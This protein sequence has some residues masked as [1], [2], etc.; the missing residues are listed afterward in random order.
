[1]F[2]VFATEYSSKRRKR[3]W[4]YSQYV[5]YYFTRSRNKFNI[6]NVKN[7]TSCPLRINQSL[8]IALQFVKRTIQFSERTNYVVLFTRIDNYNLNFVD[9]ILRHELI[10]S[11][12]LH[13]IKWYDLHFRNSSV[14]SIIRL[15]TYFHL[16]FFFI[17]KQ[18]M[19]IFKKSLRWS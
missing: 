2:S 18:T 14:V 6:K 19:I 11:S 12:D 10:L 3:S 5:I 4:T 15:S 8:R 1:M 7:W 13:Q 17:N 9:I 16:I